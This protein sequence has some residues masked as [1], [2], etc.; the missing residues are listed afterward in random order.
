MTMKISSI[1]FAPAAVER[2][3][4]RDDAADREQRRENP[5]QRE[6]KKDG[7]SEE[8]FDVEQ[9][10]REIDSFTNENSSQAYGLNAR[11]EG[12]GPGLRVTLKDGS[13]AVIRQFTGE[14]FLQLRE[15]AQATGRG[16]LLDKKL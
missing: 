13:G 12:S 7:S 15:A 16:K 3:R 9:L 14:E 5:D 11:M 6:P 10:T 8:K 1:P 4:R 2:V